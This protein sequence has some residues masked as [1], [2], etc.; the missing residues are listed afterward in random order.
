MS[1]YA[2]DNFGAYQKAMELFDWDD[3]RPPPL[4]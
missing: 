3:T 1:Q 4:A 2:V